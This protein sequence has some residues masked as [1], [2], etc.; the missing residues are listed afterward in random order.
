VNMQMVSPPTIQ[1]NSGP[2]LPGPE[3]IRVGC[4]DSDLLAFLRSSSRLADV[5]KSI[6]HVTV[7]QTSLPTDPSFPQ[8]SGRYQLFGDEVQFF[9]H[10]PFEREVKYRFSFDPKLA[11]TA[12]TV[13]P[14]HLEFL[15]P[16]EQELRPRTKVTQVFP[17]SDVLPENLLRFYVCF[18][19]PMQR[20]LAL[21]E[22]SLRDS[23]GKQVADTLYRPPVEL[24]DRSMQRLTV[25]LDPGRLKRWVGPNIALGLPLKAGQKYSLEIGLGMTDMHGRPLHETFRKDFVVSDPA[26]DYISIGSWNILSPAA[27]SRE[28]LV[29]TFP[30]PLDWALLF[31]TITVESLDGSVVDGR[32]SVDQNEKRWIFTPASPWNKGA[33]RIRVGSNLEDVCGN[34]IAGAFERPLRK[35]L[36]LVKRK[37]SSLTFRTI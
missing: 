16:R 6:F 14:F 15:I 29:L 21:K 17:S 31:H 8:V 25:L 27:H 35:G 22:I 10:L 12:L 26:R 23:D 3:N 34:T 1:I 9:P 30:E 13:E 4:L 32:I 11:A 2:S 24:W 20:G 19:N 36:N 37:V 33:H 18:S 28:A 5:L 7:A